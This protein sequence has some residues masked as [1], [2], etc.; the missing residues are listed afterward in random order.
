MVH[1]AA[2][3]GFGT[4]TTAEA[5]ER[6]RPSYHPEAVAWLVEGLGIGPGR[7][8]V[9]LAA[10]TGKLT[11]LLLPTG[12]DL[13]AVEPVAAMRERLSEQLP[14]VDVWPGTA[15][16]LPVPPAA[17][18]AIVVGQAF[19]WFDGPAA[20]AEIRRAL[21]PGGGL[22]LI[23]NVR[24]LTS[25]LQAAVE[26]LTEPH[27][28]ATPSQRSGRWRDAFDT[29]GIALEQHAVTYAQTVDAEALADR[30]GSTSFIAALP[31]PVRLPLLDRV[32]TL[33]PEGGAGELGYTTTAYRCHP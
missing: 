31:D 26:D 27:R 21:R 20:L 28:G 30:V 2:A 22:G 4:A 3:I 14:D 29:A 11:R 7:R 33:V 15:E 23:W 17:V 16:K 6:G 12:A 13:L 1:E 5:Y 24:D 18:D 10:G 9:D 19:H 32:R 25:P 8:V